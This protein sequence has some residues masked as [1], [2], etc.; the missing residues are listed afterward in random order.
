MASARLG[1]G[2]SKTRKKILEMFAALFC[3]WLVKNYNIL[4]KKEESGS[5][6][7]NHSVSALRGSLYFLFDGFTGQSWKD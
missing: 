3:S 1:K 4:D 2:Q 7:T 6:R 5:F